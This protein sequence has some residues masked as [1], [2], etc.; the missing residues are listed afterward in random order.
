[1]THH[2]E[3]FKEPAYKYQPI[4]FFATTYLVTWVSWFVAAAVS[5]L[6]GGKNI[7]VLLLA[8]NQP[9]KPASEASQ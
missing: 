3:D 7:Y 6:P 8:R 2:Q 4:R 9:V 5:Y 1:M